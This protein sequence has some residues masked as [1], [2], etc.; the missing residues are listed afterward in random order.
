LRVNLAFFARASLRNAAGGWPYDGFVLPIL[1]C[2]S[3]EHY[4]ESSCV[5]S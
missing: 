2:R 4:A 5:S 1:S 3:V